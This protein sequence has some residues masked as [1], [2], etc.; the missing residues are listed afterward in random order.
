MVRM[1][2]EKWIIKCSCSL[3]S[4]VGFD[5]SEAQAMTLVGMP[6]IDRRNNN[7]N[8]T[9]IGTIDAIC[10]EKD[11]VYMTLYSYWLP[12]IHVDENRKF[13][14]FSSVSFEIEKFETEKKFPIFFQE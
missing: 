14:S 5:I 6:I 1:V 10:Y 11:L 12:E 13:Q 9:V 2:R 7:N 4:L 8:N 3:R